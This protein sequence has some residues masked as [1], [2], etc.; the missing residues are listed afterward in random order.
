[1]NYSHKRVLVTGGAGFIG[2]ELVAQLAADGAEVTIVDTL[3]NGRRENV[4]GLLGKRVALAV[5]DIRDRET[6][7]RLME[8]VDMVFHLAC[9]GVRHSFHS[10]LENH[11]VNATGTLNLLLSAREKGIKRF[12][13]VSSSE[14]YGPA[15]SVPISEEHPA[16]PLQVYGASKLAGEGYARAFYES[17]RYPT[18]VIRPFNTYGPRSHH[19]GD[20]GEVI[21]KFLL[22]SLAGRPLIIF[23]DG[24]QTRDFTYV[25]DTAKGILLAGL[26]DKVVGETI[27]VGSSYEISINDLA[28]EVIAVTGRKDTRV[29]YD[30]PRPG[31]TPRLYAETTKMTE[32]LDFKPQISLREGLMK[33]KDWY[34]GLSVSPEKLLEEEVVHN[35]KNPSEKKDASKRKVYSYR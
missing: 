7:S 5:G 26:R 15:R 12:V 24:T 19:E 10:P 33:L 30:A 22:R 16:F 20:S 17:Y 34:L 29:Q 9:L 18:V 32:L 35:W 13:H 2:S 4:D 14:I 8:G 6:L 11:E 31:D 27:N 23:G 21:P 1:M 3:T 25:S 28:R